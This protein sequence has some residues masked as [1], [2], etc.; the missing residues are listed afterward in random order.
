MDKLIIRA[1][2]MRDCEQLT[3]MANLP[4]YRHGTLRM[5][6][7]TVEWMRKRL[8]ASSPGLTNIV[9]ELD[10]TIVGTASLQRLDGR[11]Q[12]AATL[13][14]GVHDDFQGKGIG[15][16]LM[17]ALLDV[18]DN[19]LAVPRIELVVNADNLAAIRLYEKAGF[20]REGLF[21]GYAFRAGQY[22]DAIPMAR[23][24]AAGAV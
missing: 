6:F 11:R 24:R 14:M 1:A 8:E 22:V 9:A 4:L 23:I 15:R 18:A 3:A 20:E 13:G 12:H 5:P 10:G 19:W 16:A 2:E 7:Q 17:A 21:R